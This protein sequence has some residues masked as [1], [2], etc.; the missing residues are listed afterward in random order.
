MI[1]QANL[2]A[3]QENC[4]FSSQLTTTGHF[5][6]APAPE[7]STKT[8]TLCKILKLHVSTPEEKVQTLQTYFPTTQYV[9]KPADFQVLAMLLLLMHY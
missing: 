6:C 1:R 9:V 8:P 3:L 2:Q 7:P 4:R 5:L